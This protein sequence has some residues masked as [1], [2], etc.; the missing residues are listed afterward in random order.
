MEKRDEESQV[1]ILGVWESEGPKDLKKKGRRR[2]APKIVC[3]L[4]IY[5]NEETNGLI[6][7]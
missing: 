5:R 1:L 7:G 4:G 2:R 6:M 3:L